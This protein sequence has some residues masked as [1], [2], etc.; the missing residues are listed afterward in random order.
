MNSHAS[1]NYK[2][3]HQYGH[4]PLEE[5]TLE[6]ATHRLSSADDMGARHTVGSSMQ[7]AQADSETVILQWLM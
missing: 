4:L 7:S 1:R 2:T 6:E 3:C 5:A